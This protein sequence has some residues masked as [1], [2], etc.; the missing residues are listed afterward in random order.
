MSWYQMHHGVTGPRMLETLTFNLCLFHSTCVSDIQSVSLYFI[1][2][3]TVWCRYCRHLHS[4]CVSLYFLTSWAVWC[5]P[6]SCLLQ[7]QLLWY[8]WI[9]YHNFLENT[10]SSLFIAKPSLLAGSGPECEMCCVMSCLQQRATSVP[11]GQ[12]S[13]SE[14][15]QRLFVWHNQ[16]ILS[17]FTVLQIEPKTSNALSLTDCTLKM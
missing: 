16:Q 12:V 15:C 9:V 1:Y 14:C 10:F 13:A 11:S 6:H 4:T 17:S 3:W 7:S 8:L 2:S 5:R